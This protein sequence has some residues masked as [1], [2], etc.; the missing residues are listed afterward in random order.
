MA[1]MSRRRPDAM[2]RPTRTEEVVG[3]PVGIA[4]S[5]VRL[6]V[7]MAIDAVGASRGVA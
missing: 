3:G 4:G 5:R 2:V 7:R 1:R 6:D